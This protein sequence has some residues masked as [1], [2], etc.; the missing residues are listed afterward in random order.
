MRNRKLASAL[1]VAIRLTIN[2]DLAVTISVTGLEKS[3]GL[4]IGQSSSRGAEVLQEQSGVEQREVLG[5][6]AEI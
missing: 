2:S 3:L 5:N 6:T 1:K 4:S